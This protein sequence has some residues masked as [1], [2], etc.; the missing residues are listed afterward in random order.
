MNSRPV[1]QYYRCGDG[2]EFVS[3]AEAIEYTNT[4][5]IKSGVIISIEVI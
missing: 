1:I 3:Y 5:Y 4:V 2:M